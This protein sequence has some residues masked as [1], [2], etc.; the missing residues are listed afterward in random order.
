M[1]S[2][3]GTLSLS[4]IGLLLGVVPNAA[5]AATAGVVESIKGEAR[6]NDRTL[7]LSHWVDNQD[8]VTTGPGARLT[9]RMNDGQQLILE[10]NTEVRITDFQYRAADPKADRAV[11]GLVKGA[12]RVVSG[13]IARRSSAAFALRVPQATIVVRGG[14]DFMV[15]L[16]NPAYLAVLE[17]SVS[18]ANT[19]GTAVFGS[20]VF[21]YVSSSTA[22]PMVVPASTFPAAAKAAF[23]DLGGGALLR[24]AGLGVEGGAAQGAGP[25]TGAAQPMSTGAM[26]AIGAAVAVGIAAAASRGGSSSTTSH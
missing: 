15:A 11:L 13:A 6:T 26:V 21:G 25:A 20:G 23:A 9:L 10:Q 14:A 18:A 3:L 1:K 19:A 4:F 24:T 16:V 2:I 17:G 7:G 22:A 12:L 8:T 5:N